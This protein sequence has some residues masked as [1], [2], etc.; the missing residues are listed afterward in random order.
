MSS[1]ARQLIQILFIDSKDS[2][3]EAKLTKKFISIATCL[4]SAVI[5]VS[6]TRYPPVRL[7]RSPKH[8][9]RGWNAMGCRRT[10]ARPAALAAMASDDSNGQRSK[11]TSPATLG[12]IRDF[13]EVLIGQVCLFVHK[14]ERP[15]ARAQRPTRRLLPFGGFCGRNHDALE[16]ILRCLH[17]PQAIVI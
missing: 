3:S 11:A 9:I 5:T 7:S 1:V 17:S 16:W 8:A 14:V 4:L 10:L 2:G 6:A 12:L 13:Q 15:G